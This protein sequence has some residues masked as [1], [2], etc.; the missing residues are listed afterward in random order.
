MRTTFAN[1]ASL[2]AVELPAA[3]T[4][5]EMADRVA[6][7]THALLGASAPLAPHPTRS[8]EAIAAL[9]SARTDWSIGTEDRGA[10]VRLA[11]DRDPLFGDALLERAEMMRTDRTLDSIPAT[12]APGIA[13]PTTPE[14]TR[15]LLRGIAAIG[16]D[17]PAEAYRAFTEVLDRWR[18]DRI[19][20]YLTIALT[21][22]G[23]PADPVSDA[24]LALRLLEVDPTDEV[25][26]SRY[27]RSGQWASADALRATL[28]DLGVYD[29]LGEERTAIDA[30]FGLATG[31]FEG[32]AARFGVLL[33]SN[34]ASVYALHQQAAAWIL[35]GSCP[36]AIAS[37]YAW[38]D[39]QEARGHGGNLGW[40][41][42]LAFQALV[43]EAQWEPALAVLDRWERYDPEHHEI[44]ENRRLVAWASTSDTTEL[45]STLA[46]EL[47]AQATLTVRSVTLLHLLSL[48]GEEPGVLRELADR[49]RRSAL[50]LDLRRD[51]QRGLAEVAVRL[52]AFAT[53]RETP[54][55]EAGLTAL[56]DAR[57]DARDDTTERGSHY[58][59]DGWF[60]YAAALD[61][62]ARPDEARDAYQ[63]VVDAG[64]ARLYRTVLYEKA[65][66]RLAVLRPTGTA[67]EGPP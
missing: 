30:E 19:A 11:V 28:H 16:Q 32:A 45:A 47:R 2:P 14:R 52:D 53:L 61:A 58:R 26:I 6:E 51:V 24:R 40:S 48:I 21:H 8:E 44:V 55:N 49:A 5:L 64:Y 20:I 17:D 10:L 38:I 34:P 63:R 31:D 59:V 13:S 60:A 12:V 7:A 66:A 15:A 41:Y 67:T 22:H 62:C 56:R 3:A 4:A 9:V 43:C 36:E 35:A 18:F 50:D 23:G 42:S 1:G 27:I 57:R 39:A 25:A 29:A 33:E 46:D 54:C 65:R 37:M